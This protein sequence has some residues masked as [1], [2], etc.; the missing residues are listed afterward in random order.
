MPI[1]WLLKN[2]DDADE[3]VMSDAAST[4]GIGAWSTQGRA[5]Q[6]KL[7]DTI[8]HEAQ[9]A[10]PSL[11]GQ[12]VAISVLE[13]LGSLIAA[14]L[15]ASSW[16][17]KSISFYN[18]NPSAAAAI[19][20]KCAKLQRHDMNF[21][22]REFAQIATDNTYMFWG[23]KIDGAENERADALSRFE[24]I[25]DEAGFVMED[26]NRVVGIANRILRR[27]MLHVPENL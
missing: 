10:R 6:I 15:W 22:I 12:G 13:M 21:L 19:V 9:V 17:G 7:S 27:L 23:I 20:H 11:Q 26:K 8:W 16:S 25:D 24:K 2:P 18:D 4:V 1:D 5:F 14:H 3:V